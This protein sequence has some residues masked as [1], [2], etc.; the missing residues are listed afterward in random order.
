MV[1]AKIDRSYNKVSRYGSAVGRVMVRESTL[2]SR[3]EVERMLYPDYDEALGVS[4]D[5]AYGPYLEDAAVPADIESGLESFLEEQYRF[6]DEAC[7]GTLIA[8]FMRMKYDYHNLRVLAKRDF[9][10]GED[11]ER[12]FSKLGLVSVE[13]LEQ[14][15]NGVGSPDIPADLRGAVEKVRVAGSSGEADS[16]LFDSLVDRA[17]FEGRL[18]TARQEGSRPLV[19]YCRCAVDVANL[20]VM[21][22]GLEFAKDPSFYAVALAEGGEFPRTELLSLAGRPFTE[23]SARF[24]N[25]RYGTMVAQVLDEGAE[26]VRL[27][28][29]DRTTDD[30]L[31][32]KVV[33]FANVSV[34]PERVV[35]YMLTRE[36]EVAILRIVFVG[37][38][39][40]LSPAVIETRLPLGYLKAGSV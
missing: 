22:R 9:L 2:L 31:M 36:T 26:S 8:R 5:T 1:L 15:V 40:S 30:C 4:H 34:G 21:L 19:K 11:G 27:T 7:S 6:L 20:M 23:V 32:E 14:A 33:G 24:L 10:G 12:L 3:Q 39:N 28:S 25:S 37:K 17:F 38:L 13:V 29:L 35:R 16:Q 18:L